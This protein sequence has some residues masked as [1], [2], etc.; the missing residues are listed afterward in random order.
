M[1]WN[2]KISTKISIRGRRVTNL[3]IVMKSNDVAMTAGYLL[4][5]GDFIADLET[6]ERWLI[7]ITGIG[8]EHTICSLPSINFLLMTLHA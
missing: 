4:E 3:E 5:D 7:D 8:I 6:E 2:N 1:S